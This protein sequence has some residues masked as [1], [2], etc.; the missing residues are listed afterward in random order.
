MLSSAYGQCG[1]AW[2]VPT[3][4]QLKSEPKGVMCTTFIENLG[5]ARMRSICAGTNPRY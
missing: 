3:H 4:S 5:G 2:S 1:G